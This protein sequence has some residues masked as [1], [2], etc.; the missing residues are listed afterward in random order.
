MVFNLISG[1]VNAS[2]SGSGRGGGKD[3]EGST[4]LA[5]AG[6]KSGAENSGDVTAHQEKRR[7]TGFQRECFPWGNYKHQRE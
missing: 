5:G 1:S 6:I 2:R 4:V 7:S 3:K